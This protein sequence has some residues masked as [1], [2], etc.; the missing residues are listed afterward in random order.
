LAIVLNPTEAQVI[1]ALFNTAAEASILTMQNKIEAV[2][3]DLGKQVAKRDATAG[4]CATSQTHPG[5]VLCA[6]LP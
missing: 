3:F 2:C 6:L 1:Q 5:L 4:V